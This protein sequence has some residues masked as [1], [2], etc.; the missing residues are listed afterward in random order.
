V[1]EQP[2]SLA[3]H[4]AFV[5]MRLADFI[6]LR[7]NLP[8]QIGQPRLWH[9][10]Y[11]AAFLHD[12]GKAMPG[13]QAI[14]RKD[15]DETRKEQWRG[16]RHE[17]YSLA[18]LD[19]IVAGLDQEEKQLTAWAIVSHHRDADFI[20]ELYG[21]SEQERLEAHFDGFIDEHLL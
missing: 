21:G 8:Q 20:R 10:L 19:W 1:G 14:L 17:V 15:G 11:W 6:K 13:F 3:Q 4:T 16:Q 5:L 12:F 7:P 9:C 2:E 18:F